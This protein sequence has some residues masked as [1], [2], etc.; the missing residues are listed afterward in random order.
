MEVGP[1]DMSDERAETM[2]IQITIARKKAENRIFF[3]G[4]Y[5]S[6]LGELNSVRGQT[7]VHPGG[8][9][10]RRDWV[11]RMMRSSILGGKSPPRTARSQEP[12]MGLGSTIHLVPQ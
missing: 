5:P 1:T 8:Y 3:I 2:P 4:I 9:L 12:Y 6:N 11:F 10:N 7:L